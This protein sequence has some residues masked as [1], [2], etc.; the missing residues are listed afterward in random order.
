MKS[1]NF[2]QIIYKGL[3]INANFWIQNQEIDS[4]SY[5]K[6]IKYV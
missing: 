6:F 1:R 2:S 5:H 4:S 3:N